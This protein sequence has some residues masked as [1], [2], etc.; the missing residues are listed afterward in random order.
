[1]V[2]GS[3]AAR[4]RSFPA[5]GLDAVDFLQIGAARYV[6]QCQ[7]VDRSV[8]LAAGAFARGRGRG[9]VGELLGLEQTRTAEIESGDAGRVEEVVAEDGDRGSLDDGEIEGDEVFGYQIENVLARC[10]R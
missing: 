1:M 4:S 3:A 7:P 5:G 9:D 10:W 6:G 8:A 2:V